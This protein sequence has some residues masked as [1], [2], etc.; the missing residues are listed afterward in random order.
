LRLHH[1]RFLQREPMLAGILRVARL[2]PQCTFWRFLAALHLGVAR[3]LLAVQ[4]RMRERVRQSTN[5]DDWF[6]LHYVEPA[7]RSRFDDECGSKTNFG[8]GAVNHL[9]GQS[10]GRNSQRSLKTA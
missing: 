9:R 2:P 5:R 4:W 3:Q 7:G 10:G 8:N 6:I 1:L